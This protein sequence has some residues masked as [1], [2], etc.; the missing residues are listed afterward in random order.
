MQAVRALGDCS[1]STLA[2][3][4][5]DLWQALLGVGRAV[6]ALYLAKQAA[7]LR[8]AGYT[9]DGLQ[10]VLDARN[11]RTSMV[12]TRFGKIMFCRPMGR[13]VGARHRSDLPIDRELGLCS[14][15]SLGTVTTVVQLCALMAFAGARKLF[16]QFH[17]WAPST[18]STLRMVDAVG[19]QAKTFLDAEVLDDDGTILVIQVDGRGAPMI[20]STE[21]ARRRQPKRKRKGTERLARRLKWTPFFGPVA[22]VVKGACSF[23]RR[24]PGTMKQTRA[25]HTPAFKAKVALEAVREQQSVPELARKYGVAANQIYK[26]K[27]LFVEQ[28]ALVFDQNAEPSGGAGSE[29]ED[30]LLK[31]IGELT[32]ERDFLSRGLERRR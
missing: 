1:T 8:M 7:R 22:K 19:A 20:S 18:R 13:A 14:T 5:H 17:G 6:I 28:A 24:D 10:Y 12:G 29:R 31:K 3:I 9:H 15:F 26:W 21:H 32:V 11:R 2:T 27:K 25:R 16:A 30:E 4:E 23:T